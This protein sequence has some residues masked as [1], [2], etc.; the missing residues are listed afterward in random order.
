MYKRNTNENN[1]GTPFLTY[2][3]GQKSKSLTAYSFEGAM[4]KQI[5]PILWVEM[6][7]HITHKVV[8]LATSSKVAYYIYILQNYTLPVLHIKLTHYP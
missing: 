1:T 5:L 2:L 7:N 6:Q 4:G 3:L 8:N